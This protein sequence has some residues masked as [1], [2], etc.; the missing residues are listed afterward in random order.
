MTESN[1]SHRLPSSPDRRV[2]VGMAATGTKT[3]FS[4]ANSEISRPSAAWTRVVI[5]GSYVASWP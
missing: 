4:V 3:R 1:Q 5:G 2:F